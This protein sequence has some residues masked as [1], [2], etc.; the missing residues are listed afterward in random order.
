[1]AEESSVPK[2]QATIPPSEQSHALAPEKYDTASL[3]G[4][5]QQNTLSQELKELKAQLA[6]TVKENEKLREDQRI[7]WF[8]AGGGTIIIG[9]LLGLIS[10]HTRKR[11]PSLL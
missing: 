7:N 2:Q 8:L 4:E 3:I 6:I 10:C 5:S 11:K 9:W 1:M